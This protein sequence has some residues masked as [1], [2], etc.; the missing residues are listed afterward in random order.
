MKI[1]K[2]ILNVPPQFTGGQQVEDI[3]LDP[4]QGALIPNVGDRYLAPHFAMDIKFRKFQFE[5]GELW[6]FLQDSDS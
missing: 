4:S 1:T 2:I 3:E 5:K 6:V